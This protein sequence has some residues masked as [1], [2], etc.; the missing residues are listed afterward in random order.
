MSQ[1]DSPAP[2]SARASS[3]G[4]ASLRAQVFDSALSAMV[5]HDAHGRIIDCNTGAETLLGLSRA[6][7]LGNDPLSDGWAT[8]RPD[9]SPMSGEEQPSWRALESGESQVGQIVGIRLANGRHRWLLVN[10]DV[11][12][13]ESKGS[14]FA[15]ASFVD[16]SEHLRLE[17]WQALTLSLFEKISQRWPLKH[18][19]AEIVLSV[20][21]QLAGARCSIH[22]LSDDR[23][24]LEYGIAPSMPAGY[25]D[26]LEGLEINEHVGSC[27]AS[28]T[29]GRTFVVANVLEHANWSAYVD[30]PRTYGFRACWSE[31]VFDDARRTIGTFAVYY[32]EIREPD[33]EDLALLQ[34]ASALASLVMQQHGARERLTLAAALFEQGSEAVAVTGADHR[35]ERVNRSFERLTGFSAKEVTGA[36]PGYLPASSGGGD[37]YASVRQAINESGQWSGEVLIRRKN[38]EILPAWLSAFSVKGPDGNVSHIVHSAIDISEAKSQAARIRQLAFYDVLTGLPNRALVTDRLKQALRNADR[39]SRTLGLLFVD[40]NRFKEINDTQGHEV[41]DEVLVAVSQRFAAIA[42]KG[43]TLA[44]LGG[45][46]FLLL[47]EGAGEAEAALLAERMQDAL[48]EPVQVREHAFVVGASIGIALYPADGLVLDELMKHA[49]IAMY[50]AKAQGSGARFYQ[51]EMSAGLGERVSLARDLRT[52]LRKDGQLALAFQPQFDLATGKLS[53]A[54]ALM[55]WTHPSLGPISP[56]VFIPLAEERDMIL[57]VG[58]WVLRA[59]CEQLAEWQRRGQYLPGRLAINFSAH[60]LDAADAL[61]RTL[62]AMTAS[63]VSPQHLEL[64]LTETALMRN[65]DHAMKTM[66]DFRDAGLALAIDDFGMGYSSLSYLKRFPVERLKIDMSFVRDMLIDKNDF[67]IVGSIVAMAKPLNLSTVAEGVEHGGQADALR[68]LG[69]DHAQGYLFGRP[70]SAA[71]FAE[72]WLPL[73]QPSPIRP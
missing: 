24:R 60:Q 1:P 21:Q 55:R 19:L 39:H 8:V 57:E 25:M 46:E 22:V 65:I 29:L 53:G 13:D 63:G 51:P 35:I 62:R 49:D 5:I 15:V 47:A 40:L 68:S 42:G 12:N 41:G 7:L 50:R 4:V 73:A 17:S 11:F 18:L 33:D 58:D 45:D 52:A 2:P 14:R 28:A 26:A 59:A 54:E 64:E 44:R 31:P 16:I 37:A 38:G 48:A 34:Q 32:D 6:Q 72:R 9:G 3:P 70:E 69:C 66:R 61:P 56:G 67:A 23:T 71:H 20:Q 43:D 27:G 36:E 30:L 10:A